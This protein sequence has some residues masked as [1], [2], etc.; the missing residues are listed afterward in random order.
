[1]E[2]NLPNGEHS[3]YIKWNKQKKIKTNVCAC[4]QVRMCACMYVCMRF[5][6]YKQNK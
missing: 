3:K 1:M 4:V 6:K 2:S 5:P